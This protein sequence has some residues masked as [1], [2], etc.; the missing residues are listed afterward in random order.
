MGMGAE[1]G[2]SRR[3]NFW[4]EQETETI[5]SSALGYY[6]IQASFIHRAWLVEKET[7]VQ[8]YKESVE[9][10][11]DKNLAPAP[12]THTHTCFHSTAHL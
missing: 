5:L 12:H 1:K 11:F 2:R 9:V 8:N 7:E 6:A 3:E 10:Q 4:V